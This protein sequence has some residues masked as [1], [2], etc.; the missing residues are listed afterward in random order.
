[1]IITIAEAATKLG[2]SRQRVQQ[3]IAQGRIMAVQ[4]GWKYL[5]ESDSVAAIPPARRGRPPG[6]KN[7]IKELLAS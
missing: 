7:K 4:Q 6:S 2:V 1:M 5:I 3:L